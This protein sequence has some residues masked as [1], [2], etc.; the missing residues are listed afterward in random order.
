MCGITLNYV[1]YALQTM[2]SC[3]AEALSQIYKA[4]LDDLGGCLLHIFQ[5]LTQCQMQI[6]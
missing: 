5:T 6:S 2:N 4:L 1:N 3:V